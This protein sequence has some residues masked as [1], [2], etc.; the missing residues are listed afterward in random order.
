M[1]KA[2]RTIHIMKNVMENPM[3]ISTF[4]LSLAIGQTILVGQKKEPAEI[5]KIEFFE[6]SGELVIGTTRGPRKAFTF[7]LPA[8]TREEEVMCPADKYR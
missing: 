6:K 1:S 3:K 4:D 7:S 2:E 5:T 8:G